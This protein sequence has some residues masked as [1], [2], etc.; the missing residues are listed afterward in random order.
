MLRGKDIVLIWREVIL[1]VKPSEQA[2]KLVEVAQQALDKGIEKAV[3][4][5]DC[6]I[7]LQRFKQEVE[8]MDLV[9]CVILQDM[10]LAS[11]CMKIQKY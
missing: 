2:Q 1:L 4:E 5:I 7:F 11:G 8:N 10:V 3:Q 6:P 9:W